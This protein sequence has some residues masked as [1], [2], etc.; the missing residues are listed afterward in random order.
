MRFEID[1]DNRILVQRLGRVVGTTSVRIYPGGD[2]HIDKESL[3]E[4]SSRGSSA[5]L[6][7]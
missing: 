5:K 4:V 6:Y 2:H 3:L 1:G 7:L